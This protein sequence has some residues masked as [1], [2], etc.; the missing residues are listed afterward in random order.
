MLS[1][2]K[3]YYEIVGLNLNSIIERLINSSKINKQNIMRHLIDLYHQ[4]VILLFRKKWAGLFHQAT[5][6]TNYSML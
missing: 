1:F 4:L 2:R 5:F 3:Y 6:S